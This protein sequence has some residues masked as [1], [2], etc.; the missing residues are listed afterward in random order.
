M[1]KRDR[2]QLREAYIWEANLLATEF[3]WNCVFCKQLAKDALELNLQFLAGED[4]LFR[5]SDSKLWIRC[6]NCS[7]SCHYSCVAKACNIYMSPE[8]FRRQGR[9]T[10]CGPPIH[11]K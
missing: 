8:K 2:Q 11:L 5:D 1:R 10:C 9:H 3:G 4:V 7:T 6:D